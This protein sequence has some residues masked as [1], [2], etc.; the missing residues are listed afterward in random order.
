MNS[1]FDFLVSGNDI[2]GRPAIFRH[3]VNRIR[4]DKDN[5]Q[6]LETVVG[7]T[8]TAIQSYPGFTAP[9]KSR[10]DNGLA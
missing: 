5:R 7:Y 2:G 3:N 8:M 9:V 4:M 6:A 1:P 10:N